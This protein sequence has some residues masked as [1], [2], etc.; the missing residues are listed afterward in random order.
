MA[1]RIVV[2]Q[3]IEA[4]IIADLSR[5]GP[6]LHEPRPGSRSPRDELVTRSLC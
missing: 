1:Y 3:P 2:A 6:V 5:L 4:E